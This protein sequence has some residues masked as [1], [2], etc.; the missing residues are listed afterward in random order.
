MYK[1]TMSIFENMKPG[2]I[3]R[4]VSS[5]GKKIRRSYFSPVYLNGVGSQVFHTCMDGAKDW[6]YCGSG[7]HNG[8]T[9][10]KLIERE[11]SIL[12]MLNG[13]EGANFGVQE[14]NNII[15]AVYKYFDTEIIRNIKIEDINKLLNI[16]SLPDKSYHVYGRKDELLRDGS[17]AKPGTSA[18]NTAYMYSHRKARCRPE[19]KDVVFTNMYYMIASESDYAIPQVVNYCLGEVTKDNRINMQRMLFNSN[20]CASKNVWETRLRAVA[21]IN[22]AKFSYMKLISGMYMLIPNTR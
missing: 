1:D 2:T 19:I 17:K 3:V 15:K 13:M 18:K 4:L 20:G 6:Y 14:A 11:P 10:V 12:F 21:Y 8:K 5:K 16:V 7:T 22:P 9:L